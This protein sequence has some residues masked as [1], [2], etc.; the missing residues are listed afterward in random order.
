MAKIITVWGNPGCGKSMFCCILAKVLTAGKK[1]AIIINADSGI[2]MLPVWMPD[3]MLDTSLSIGNV[4]SGLEINMALVAERVVILKEYPFI[5][6]MGFAAGETPFS[7]PELKYDKIR[8]LISEAAKLVDYILLDCS[9]NMLHFF[10]VAAIETADVAVRILTP[11]LRGL[12]YLK[13]HKPL[14]TDIKFH[15][16]DHLTLAGLARPFHALDEMGHLVGGFDGLLPYTKEI[17]R[18]GTGGRMF[19][20]LAY[21]NQRYV[22]SLKLVIARLSEDELPGT[23]EEI[24]NIEEIESPDTV[25]EQESSDTEEIQQPGKEAKRHG[26][27][28]K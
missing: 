9:S 6:V 15:Y 21:C 12:N 7:Y 17:E 26:H 28:F 1:K 20:A 8:S 25:S 3:R 4:L 14:L 5:G 16:D 27:F 22:N 19:R 18:C 10:T 24:D 2:P 13:S 11:D 23:D